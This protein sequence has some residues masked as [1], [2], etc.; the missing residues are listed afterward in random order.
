MKCLSF[1][2]CFHLQ[3]VIEQWLQLQSTTSPLLWNLRQQVEVIFKP[4][5]GTLRRRTPATYKL[6]RNRSSSCLCFSVSSSIFDQMVRFASHQTVEA[7]ETNRAT[8][9]GCLWPVREVPRQTV[10]LASQSKRH[11]LV[12]ER[13]TGRLATI[14]SPTD[15]PTNDNSASICPWFEL[16]KTSIA[17]GVGSLSSPVRRLLVIG[18]PDNER[19]QLMLHGEKLRH[20]TDCEAAANRVYSQVP[21]TSTLITG[22]KQGHF[23]AV[24]EHETWTKGNG[25]LCLSADKFRARCDSN[26]RYSYPLNWMPWSPCMNDVSDAVNTT[27]TE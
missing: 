12:M 17:F 18:C 23:A 13:S 26:Y 3:F 6:T 20:D 27:P 11:I 5:H 10:L 24:P 21:K 2:K 4:R 25:N 14:Q 9:L 15:K 8:L 1:F 7:F 19:H 16:T 22:R